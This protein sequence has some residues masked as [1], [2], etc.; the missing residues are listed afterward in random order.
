[1]SGGG[2]HRTRRVSERVFR[3]SAPRRRTSWRCGCRWPESAQAGAP[4]P[5]TRFAAPLASV[6]LSWARRAELMGNDGNGL[7]AALA[8]SLFNRICGAP[9]RWGLGSRRATARRSVRRLLFQ[10][11]VFTGRGKREALSVRPDQLQFGASR[12]LDAATAS[13]GAAHAASAGAGAVHHASGRYCLYHAI[14]RH[15]QLPDFGL[16]TTSMT[17][18]SC[19]SAYRRSLVLTSASAR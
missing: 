6:G 12:G 14:L 3:C 4:A 5:L 2:K 10:M 1:M 16:G 9:H 17:R 11:H 8:D 7:S 19:T 15:H 18:R 13:A